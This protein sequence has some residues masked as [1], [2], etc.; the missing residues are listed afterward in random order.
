MCGADPASGS[1]VRNNAASSCIR[2]ANCFP[3]REQADDSERILWRANYEVR[4]VIDYA[5]SPLRPALSDLAVSQE[6][7]RRFRHEMCASLV[8]QKVDAEAGDVIAAMLQ[9]SRPHETRLQEDRSAPL[10]ELAITAVVARASVSGAC[11]VQPQHVPGE[12]TANAFCYM[13]L[14]A[15]KWSPVALPRRRVA[16]PGR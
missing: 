9:L 5:A 11:R 6:F 2:C 15:D 1:Q 4:T 7:N 14:H 12:H 13:C 3:S 10:A 16:A 8:R